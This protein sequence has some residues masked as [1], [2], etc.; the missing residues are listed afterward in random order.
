MDLALSAPP[1]LASLQ[2]RLASDHGKCTR[3][4]QNRHLGPLRV[5]RLLY[6]EGPQIAHALLLH[7]PGGIAGGDVLEMD[8]ALDAGAHAL[9]TTPG[10]AKWYHGRRGGARQ[11]VQ[12]AVAENAC[13]EWLPQESILF[14]AAQAEQQLHIQLAGSARMIGW[15]ITQFGRVAA[16]EHWT[17]GRWRQHLSLWRQGRERCCERA[18]LGADDP[19][20][21]SPLGL[22]D[23]PV[24]A[25]LWAAAPD[26]KEHAE[27]LI[28]ALRARAASHGLAAGISWLPAPIEL[29]MVRA[30]GA[31]AELVRA[32]LE[33]LWRLLRP[34][35][36][37]RVA[38]RPRIWDT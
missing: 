38:Q 28:E 20:M 16:G 27:A 36:I 34:T 26:L 33:D 1:W 6:P 35:V 31:S 4:V 9:I 24:T 29:L 21:R 18:D 37:G 3:M 10:A 22:A 17:E 5:Q 32:L 30:L 19:L 25:T 7:P 14:D 11:S 8:I 15:D 2:L 13:L 12:L 23:Q